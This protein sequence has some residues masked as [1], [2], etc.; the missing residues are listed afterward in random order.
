MRVQYATWERFQTKQNA[1]EIFILKYTVY[2]QFL[3]FYECSSNIML[4]TV[5]NP[6]QFPSL[7]L[8]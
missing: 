8:N 5:K 6:F 4:S 7:P 3:L 2:V 1:E